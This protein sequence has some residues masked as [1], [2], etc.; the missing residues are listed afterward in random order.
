MKR[1]LKQMIWCLIG[2]HLGGVVIAQEPSKTPSEPASLEAKAKVCLD[3]LHA[4]KA[5]LR[6]CTTER[7]RHSTAALEEKCDA[8][9]ATYAAVEVEC[10]EIARAMAHEKFVTSIH[11]ALADIRTS[12]ASCDGRVLSYKG[13]TSVIINAVLANM[14]ADP[15]DGHTTGDKLSPS[16]MNAIEPDQNATMTAL[17]R[18]C[19][20]ELK[21]AGFKVPKTKK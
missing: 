7:D 1:H 2:A 5:D 13:L 19:S 8:L 9:A 10:N 16:E 6:N 17:Q 14:G 12:T 4:A 3:K 11:A 20:P 15:I 21:A 18:D